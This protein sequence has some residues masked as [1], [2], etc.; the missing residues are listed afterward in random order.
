MANVPVHPAPA[1]RSLQIVAAS[2]LSEDQDSEARWNAWVARGLADEAVTR[3]R[4]L[5][6]IPAIPQNGRWVDDPAAVRL[7]DLT[8]Y[9]YQIIA[10]VNPNG[11]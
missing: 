7:R 11:N 4:M 9:L 8:D 10:A 1:S 3:R 2:A 6:A 5:I